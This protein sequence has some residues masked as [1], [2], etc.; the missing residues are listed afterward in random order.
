MDENNPG[1]EISMRIASI[2]RNV[3]DVTM[4]S[5]FKMCLLEV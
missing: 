2:L 3:K 1:A 5:G 4:C